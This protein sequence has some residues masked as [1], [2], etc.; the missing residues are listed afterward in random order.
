MSHNDDPDLKDVFAGDD[1]IP[2]LELNDDDILDA[3]QHIPGY[4]D[5]STEDFRLVYHLAHRHAMERVFRGLRAERLMRTGIKPLAPDLSLDQAA[6]AIAAQNLKSLPVVDDQQRV[7]GML[8]ETDFLRHL[9]ADSFLELLL[10]MV[11]DAGAFRHRC[12]DTSV[13]EA[14]TA[15]VV[16]V[17][18]E[19]GFPGIVRAF[20]SHAGRS[21]PVIDSDGRL[22]G[23]LLRKDFLH[24]SH[25][26]GLL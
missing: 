3:M 25:L 26:E 24:A 21:M 10:E 4:I 23:L 20:H 7:I 14:M 5:I 15:E 1:D 13:R 12:H 19:Q 9:Q 8:T 11:K 2:E 18:P 22:L 6:A 16:S 17:G